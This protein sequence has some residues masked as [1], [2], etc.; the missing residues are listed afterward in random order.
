MLWMWQQ[1]RL[2]GTEGGVVMEDVDSSLILPPPTAKPNVTTI[3][4]SLL[5]ISAVSSDQ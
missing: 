2:G 4:T 3:T 1:R 5:D